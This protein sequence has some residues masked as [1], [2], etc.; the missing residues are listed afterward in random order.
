MKDQRS[1]EQNSQRNLNPTGVASMS[2]SHLFGEGSGREDSRTYNWDI[3]MVAFEG[4][5]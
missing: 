5:S 3:V 4:E 1:G 2:K